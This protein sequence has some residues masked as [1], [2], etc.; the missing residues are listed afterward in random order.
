MTFVDKQK[1]GQILKNVSCEEEKENNTKDFKVKEAGD[2]LLL[3]DSYVKLENSR[4]L[5]EASQNVDKSKSDDRII[6]EDSSDL[7]QGWTRFRIKR[8]AGPKCSDRYISN[9]Q[10]RKFDRQKDVDEYLRKSKLNIEVSLNPSKSK[11]SEMG[12]AAEDSNKTDE[13]KNKRGIGYYFGKNNKDTKNGVTESDTYT[14][15]S[16][17]KAK[18]D[19][20]S[21]QVSPEVDQK[22]E[23]SSFSNTNKR[24]CV[25]D[26]K[27]TT[28]QRRKP[29]IVESLNK[30]SNKDCEAPVEAEATKKTHEDVSEKSLEDLQSCV[31]GLKHEEVKDEVLEEKSPDKA[32]ISDLPS[33]WSR[34]EVPKAFSKQ[35]EVIVVIEAPDGKQ[36]DA[37]KKL[38]S[39]IARN[40]MNVKI[41]I[42]GPVE[43]SKSKETLSLTE[44]TK[45]DKNSATEEETVS[46]NKEIVSETRK[47][48]GKTK[49]EDTVETDR[50]LTN[51][52]IDEECD[53]EF[54]Q[55]DLIYIEEIN[56]FLAETE[57]QLQAR[58]AT[59]GDGNCWFRAVADQ[60]VSQNIPDKA[61]NHRAL[62][63]E[64]MVLCWKKIHANN[65]LFLNL[66]V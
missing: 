58:P 34:K 2:Q 15:E 22:K 12:E 66:G 44:D 40:K 1:V 39:Y 26:D 54:C 36:F 56:K 46:S 32:T 38:N 5:K 33:G 43:K 11:C 35:K 30:S 53:R 42:D 48:A 4:D 3:K 7:P 9:P 61:R 6:Y 8:L 29:N 51:Q 23:Q 21:D 19:I 28:S 49:K 62:R 64:V 25:D 17:P 52:D 27:G 65:S 47:K 24:K 63:L 20:P 14:Q 59:K 16:L 57:L 10:G 50:Y 31:N 18:D 41:S 37:Q 55:Q 45:G 13:G 60:V